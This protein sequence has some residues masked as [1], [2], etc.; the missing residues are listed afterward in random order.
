MRHSATATFG[1]PLRPNGRTFV[2]VSQSFFSYLTCIQR[3]I[4]MSQRLYGVA[5]TRK[6]FGL[7][8]KNLP[9]TEL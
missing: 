2:G 1:E 4:A 9:V 6:S 3:E 5:V 7:M 8:T